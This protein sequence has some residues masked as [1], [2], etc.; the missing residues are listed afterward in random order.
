MTSIQ[1]DPDQGRGQ[2]Q[3]PARE[4][5][6]IPVGERCRDV[7]TTSRAGGDEHV[8][9]QHHET[10]RH[11]DC[12]P[13]NQQHPRIATGEARHARRRNTA[14]EPSITSKISATAAG[15]VARITTW[16]VAM[17]R[18]CSN[19][20][21]LRRCRSTRVRVAVITTT[22]TGSTEAANP[23]AASIAIPMMRARS[24]SV[25]PRHRN[26]RNSL[27]GK[28]AIRLTNVRGPG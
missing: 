7:R 24:Q 27:G 18:L 4:D 14:H 25:T 22:H 2:C 19:V 10:G 15:R 11:P 26:V 8:Q 17:P 6:R 3:R 1:I 9:C 21:S 23:V 20:N 12:H 13:A 28:V 5:E 16:G